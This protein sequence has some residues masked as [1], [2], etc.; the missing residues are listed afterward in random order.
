MHS[1]LEESGA[2]DRR[3]VPDRGKFKPG[4]G[5]H[6]FAKIFRIAEQEEK[7]RNSLKQQCTAACLQK[8]GRRRL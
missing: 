7:I 3:N 8:A 2:R 1:G 6:G 4:S 5:S